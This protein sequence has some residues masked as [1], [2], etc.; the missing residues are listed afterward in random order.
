MVSP[1]GRVPEWAPDWFFVATEACD[2]GNSDLGFFLGGFGI[3]KNFLASVSRQGG[4]RGGGKVE[5]RALGGRLPPL[6]LP[7][8][9]SGPT[10]VLRGLLLVH[11]KSP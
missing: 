5:G 9:S 8:D 11:K 10:L 1:S 2:G 7:R 3:S 6:S 4:P